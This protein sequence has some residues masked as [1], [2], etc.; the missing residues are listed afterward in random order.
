MIDILFGHVVIKRL[1]KVCRDVLVVQVS[2]PTVEEDEHQDLGY[3]NHVH[4]LLEVGD[5]VRVFALV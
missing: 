4:L 5:F 2:E 1:V 3:E